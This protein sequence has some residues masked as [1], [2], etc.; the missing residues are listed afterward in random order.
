[1]INPLLQGPCLKDVPAPSH[2][3]MPI[4]KIKQTD[5]SLYFAGLELASAVSS[6]GVVEESVENCSRTFEVPLASGG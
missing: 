4:Q 6:V 2:V 3:S 5:F 1:M